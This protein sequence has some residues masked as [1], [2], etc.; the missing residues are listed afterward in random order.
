MRPIAQLAAQQPTVPV[1]DAGDDPVN[2][3]IPEFGGIVDAERHVYAALEV[4]IREKNIPIDPRGCSAAKEKEQASVTCR[5]RR[6]CRQSLESLASLGPAGLHE[7]LVDREVTDTADLF[8]RIRE[9]LDQPV[10]FL[11][12]FRER[13]LVSEPEGASC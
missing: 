1:H 9:L 7:A 11:Q 2:R 4:V 3:G 10:L 12:L 8:P 13:F 5:R 6:C